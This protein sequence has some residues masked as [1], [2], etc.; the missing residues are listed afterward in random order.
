MGIDLRLRAAEQP[1][2]IVLPEVDDDRVVDAARKLDSIAEPILLD[3]GSV[4][5]RCAEL[6]YERRKH[7]GI[8]EG[9]AAVAVEDPL[10]A[11]ALLVTLGEA[12]GFVAGCVR[13]TSDVV[14][15]AILG[16][17]AP[18]LVSSFFLMRLPDGRDY[19]FADCGV[20]PDPDSKQLAEIAL[21]TANSAE[22]LLEEE[23]RVAMLSYSTHGSAKHESID[24]VRNA[25][26]MARRFRPGLKLDGE[27][28]VDA[29]L[30]PAIAARKAPQSGV[31][32]QANV[33]VF[34][35]LNSG[36]IG[37]KLTQRLAGAVALGPI[38]QGLN[39]PANDL[40]RGC[41]AED[42]VDVCCVTALQCASE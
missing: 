4:R 12:D 39:R 11:A 21:Q 27:L 6:Y 37:Y 1:R 33:L 28:Q 5:D 16:I 17:G 40:S 31:A 18:G 9:D 14:R 7:K 34:P 32:G 15:A 41:T 19:L 25:T 3:V 23:P 2:R 24:K 10:L 13:S 22:L 20:N 36:N 26:L 30:V 35:D 42:I 38:L 8:S 29:A